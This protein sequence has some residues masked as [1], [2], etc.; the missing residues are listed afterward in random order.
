MGLSHNLKLAEIAVEYANAMLSHG[1]GNKMWDRL[2]SGGL[3]PSRVSNMREVKNKFSG[4]GEVPEDAKFDLEKLPEVRW[5]ASIAKKAKVGNCGEY[6]AV[7]FMFLREIRRVKRLD[8][9]LFARPG[10]HTWVVIGRALD[11]DFSDYKTWGNAAVVCDPW[12][13]V[14][15]HGSQLPR[16]LHGYGKAAYGSYLETG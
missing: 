2:L 8:Y 7:A 10:D 5:I 9:M 13:G 6:A 4:I 15:F 12:A 1:A 16:K 14:A 11:S 3:N